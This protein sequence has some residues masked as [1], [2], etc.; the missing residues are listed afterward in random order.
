MGKSPE[1]QDELHCA[2]AV[3]ADVQIE[4]GA[5]RPQGFVSGGAIAAD[6]LGHVERAR[7]PFAVD[8]MREAAQMQDAQLHGRQD[9]PQFQVHQ[10]G[11]KRH[12]REIER[13]APHG[14]LLVRL[15]LVHRI[16]RGAG[17]GRDRRLGRRCGSWFFRGEDATDGPW[18]ISSV[19]V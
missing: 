4:C 2:A 18:P 16:R 11:W 17:I 19:P 10:R 6:Q 3:I 14:R 12:E 8:R 15:G 9:L 13:P 7:Q 1:M 5:K